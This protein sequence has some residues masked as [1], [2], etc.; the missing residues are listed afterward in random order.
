MVQDHGQRLRKAHRLLLAVGILLPPHLDHH[1]R[2]EGRSWHTGS[3]AGTAAETRQLTVR[4]TRRVRGVGCWVSQMWAVHTVKTYCHMSRKR[5]TRWNTSHCVYLKHKSAIFIQWITF[6]PPLWL[7][8]CSPDGKWKYS[9][10]TT[11]DLLNKFHLQRKYCEDLV[12]LI[13][14]L[15][16]YCT[17]KKKKRGHICIS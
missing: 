5:L 10:I 4:P 1:G 17:V 11:W 2:C 8:G 13:P 12:L 16:S 6:L 9:Q 14:H 15:N 3:S 7:R